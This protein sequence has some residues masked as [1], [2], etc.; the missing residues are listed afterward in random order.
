MASRDRDMLQVSAAAVRSAEDR[1]NNRAVLHR[2]EAQ[3]AMLLE[4][5]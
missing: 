1:T 2:N 5:R 3:A 4:V